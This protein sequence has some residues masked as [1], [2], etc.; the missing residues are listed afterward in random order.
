[1][2]EMVN[3]LK[4]LA[5]Q[6]TIKEA[7]KILGVESYTLRRWEKKGLI[8]CFRNKV[9]NYRMY[10]REDIMNILKKINGHD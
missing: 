1:M 7:S 3:M 9:N 6:V 5:E 10:S 2:G 8:S 4:T